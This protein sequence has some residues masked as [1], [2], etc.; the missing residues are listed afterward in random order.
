MQGRPRVGEILLAA[1]VIDQMQL[2]AALGEQSRWGRRLGVTLIKMG[3]VEEGH[4]IRA[5]AK[6]LDLPVASLAG[7]RI[8]AEVIALVPSRVASEHGVI[9][10]FTKR[11]GRTD[12]L[13]LGM[14]DPSNLA[15]LDDL[16]FRTGM[17]I[18]PVMVGPSELGEAIDRYYHGRGPSG[19]PRTDPFHKGDTLGQSSLRTVLDAGPHP[20][21]APVAASPG[22]GDR[23]VTEPECVPECD[24]GCDSGFEEERDEIELSQ[25]APEVPDALLADVAR[26]LDET[27]RTRIV[28]KALTQLLIEKGVLTLEEVQG[29]IAAL[30]QAAVGRA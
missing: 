8:P 6:Q 4:L 2:D 7:K 17:E 19:P 1:G 9:P 27:E 26:A 16:S 13:Y 14:E 22:A 29:K 25:P 23:S 10:L 28:A 11:E 12:H 5:L 30:K 20:G 21:T 24:S 18:H 15:V 3:F